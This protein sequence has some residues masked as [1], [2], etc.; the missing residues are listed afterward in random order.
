MTERMRDDRRELAGNRTLLLDDPE[1]VWRVLTGAVDLFVV[2]VVDGRAAGTRHPLER[3]EAGG[4]LLPFPPLSRDA[5]DAPHPPHDTWAVLAAGIQGTEIE[6]VGWQEVGAPRDE[7]ERRQAEELAWRVEG[8]G[9]EDREHRERLDRLEAADRQRVQ[10]ALVGLADVL[11]P[12]GGGAASLRSDDPL[13]AACRVAGEGLGLVMRR[14]DEQ[15]GDG[16]GSSAGATGLRGVAEIAHASRVRSREVVLAGRW[17]RSD[18]GPL[19]AFRTEDGAPLALVRRRGGYR[20]LDPAS[21]EERRVDESFVRDL[22]P[23][24]VTFYRS[25]PSHSLKAAHLVRFGAFGLGRDLGMVVLVGLLGG[26][27]GLLPPIVLGKLVDTIIPAAETPRLVELVGILFAAALGSALFAVV[28]SVAVVRIESHMDAS[29]QAALWDRILGLPIPFFQRFNAGDLADRAMG[30]N[31]MRQVVSG[32]TATTLL[33]GIFSLLNVGLMLHYSPRLAMVGLALVLV[34]VS[35]T[36]GT[37]TVELRYQRRI[38]DLGGRLAGKVLQLIKAVAKLRGA[39]AERRAFAYWADDFAV[40]RRLVY[41]ARLARA[42][43]ATANAAAPAL[44]SLALFGF[45]ALWNRGGAGPVGAMTS[46]DFL[47]FIA[48]F[49]TLSTASLHAGG[50]VVEILRIV[51]IYE[52]ARPILEAVPE[53]ADERPDAGALAGEIEVARV[54]FRYHEDGPEVLRDVTLRVAPGESIAIVGSSGAGKSTLLRLL[55]GFDEPTSGAVYYDSHHLSDLDARSVRRQ[56]GVVLQ[57]GQLLGGDI[58]GNIVGALPLGMDEAWAAARMAGLEDD[59][60]AMPMGMHTLVGEGGGTLS[61]GQRQRLMIAKA[62]VNRPRLVFFD[63]ATSALDNPT[64]AVVAD[65]LECLQATRI[66]IA[67]RLSTIRHVDRIYMLDAGRI[68]ESGAYE[69]L[70]AAGGPFAEMARRQIA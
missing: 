43:L 4:L 18:A 27:L 31:A 14:P 2:R 8:I 46:G 63:E 33:A 69:E 39:G 55:L 54:S 56:V 22:E 28:R 25:F 64:Q 3:V 30:I 53:A 21:G 13:L 65:S 59:I 47:A 34:L 70:M 17:W 29:V 11:G 50:T 23:K 61:G 19:V 40:Q 52:R 62:L 6:A 7:T 42:V 35:I 20:A 9:R 41:K 57:G 5:S 10:G 32:T 24:A 37:G 51:P 58:F 1:R 26:L 15:D 38:S 60:K 67:H 36:I 16:A 66:L 45:Y 12:P 48:A 44:S 49:G 68:V